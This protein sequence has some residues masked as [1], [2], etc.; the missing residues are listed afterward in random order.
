MLSDTLPPHLEKQYKEHSLEHRWMDGKWIKIGPTKPTVPLSERGEEL[1]FPDTG[2]LKTF[3]FA[4][5]NAFIQLDSAQIPT[6][7]LRYGCTF[8]TEI[9]NGD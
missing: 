1:T 3:M 7:Q 4:R 5:S 6:F 8:E 2:Y 9:E